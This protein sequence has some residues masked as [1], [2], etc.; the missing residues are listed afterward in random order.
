MIGGQ[1]VLLLVLYLFL[2]FPIFYIG[3]LS[4]TENTVWPFPPVAYRRVVWP[5]HD[6]E[7]L[8]LSAS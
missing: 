5:P 3:Y 1:T 4:I 6:H 2:Y 7:R 8:P